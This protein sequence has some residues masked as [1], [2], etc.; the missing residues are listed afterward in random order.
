[1]IQGG[2]YAVTIVFALCTFYMGS[3]SETIRP[4]FIVFAA[5]LALLDL[6]VVAPWIKEYTKLAAKCQ[7][8]FDIKVLEIPASAWITGPSIESEAV[9]CMVQKPISD[10]EVKS[11]VHWYTG[12]F[13]GLPI[14][15]ARTIC[16]RMNL[17]YDRE[18]RKH[19]MYFLIFSTLLMAT[20]LGVIGVL[21]GL[22]LNALVLVWFA[23]LV[24]SFTILMREARRHHETL[25][26]L[27]PVIS[28]STSLKEHAIANPA[29]SDLTARSRELQDAIY[30][31]RVSNPLVFDWFYW[32]RRKRNEAIARAANKK[33]I[34]RGLQS[35]KA[36][37]K[38]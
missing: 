3:K 22:S 5:V 6:M 16:Q 23:P 2:W 29:A 8:A 27:K 19:F 35:K 17:S 33:D 36:S 18:V 26:A 20:V 12:N 7:E 31:H 10:K 21:E 28:A 24:P 34:R 11:L 32:V 1:M 37:D 15:V 13:A 25:E 14:E 9:S 30:R 4:Y 38:P